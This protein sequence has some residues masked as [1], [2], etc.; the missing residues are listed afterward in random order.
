M[1]RMLNGHQVVYNHAAQFADFVHI[2]P[3]GVGLPLNL[4]A[5]AQAIIDIRGS[6]NADWRSIFSHAKGDI[7]WNVH[8]SVAV[9]VDTKMI[10]DTTFIKG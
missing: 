6:V 2:V 3:M 8:P 9:H 1:L 4:A 7:H 10:V 5:K